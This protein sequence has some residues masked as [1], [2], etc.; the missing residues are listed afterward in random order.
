MLKN[1]IH[2]HWDE[3]LEILESNGK[4]YSNAARQIYSKYNYDYTV[5]AGRKAIR[6]RLL[7][8]QHTGLE[9]EC[10]AVGIPLDNVKHYW[11]KGK[12]YSINVNAQKE[13]DYGQAIDDV[14]SGYTFEK[15]KFTPAKKVSDLSLIHI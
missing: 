1:P 12:H 8:T 6:T 15:K 13:T 5:D 10:D 4:D 2:N 3:V 7:N 11:H 9:A 14:L